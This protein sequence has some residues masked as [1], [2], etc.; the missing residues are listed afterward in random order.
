M[1]WLSSFAIKYKISQENGL[2]TGGKEG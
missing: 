2:R 1:K